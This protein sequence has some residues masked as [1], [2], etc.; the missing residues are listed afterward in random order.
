MGRE[1]I[2]RGPEEAGSFTRWLGEKFDALFGGLGESSDV[3]VVL[4]IASSAIFVTAMVVV[5]VRGRAG[6]WR[7]RGAR[8]VE[9]SEVV[10]QRVEELRARARAA[11]GDGDLVLALRTHLFALVVGLG[12][13]GDLEF[14]PTWTDRELLERGHPEPRVKA[15]LSGLLDELDPTTYGQQAVSQEDVRRLDWLPARSLRN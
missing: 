6:R 13:V 14:R 12:E 8:R 11:E 10:R 1:G 4:L 7:R 5:L 2:P 9:P 15:W 3:L